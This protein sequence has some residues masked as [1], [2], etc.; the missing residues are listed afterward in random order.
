MEANSAT[1]EQLV[2]LKNI[3]RSLVNNSKDISPLN[4]L[5]NLILKMP[6]SFINKV[7]PIILSAFYPILKNISD[8]KTW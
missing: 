3:C 5:D 2:K 8:N 7:Q 4:E 1:L 6:G